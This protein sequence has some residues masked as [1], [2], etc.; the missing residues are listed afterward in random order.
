MEHGD[1]K[2]KEIAEVPR[3]CYCCLDFGSFLCLCKI[4]GIMYRTISQAKQ[5]RCKTSLLELQAVLRCSFISFRK[6]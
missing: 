6:V 2:I 4:R 1:S 5:V 3:F